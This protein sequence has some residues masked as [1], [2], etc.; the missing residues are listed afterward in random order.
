MNQ[1]SGIP[2][3]EGLKL[4][5]FI[6]VLSSMSP[7]FIL[8]SIRGVDII[9]DVYFITGCVAMAILPTGILLFREFLAKRQNDTRSLVIGRTEDHRGHV[10]VY[11]FAILLPFYRQNVDTWRDFFALVVALLFILFLFWHLNYHYMNIIFAAR[12]YRVLNIL[13]PDED[14]EY[15]SVTNFTLITRRT[16]V[17]SSER[18]VAY[19]LS[20]M[21]YMEKGK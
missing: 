9:P 13:P 21:V 7:L 17:R 5:R 1:T 11:L 12:G 20:N 15:S 4:L 16:T 3:G 6:M 10:L 2:H 18:V 14:N 8:W 19:R